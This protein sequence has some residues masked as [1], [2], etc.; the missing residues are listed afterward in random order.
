LLLGLASKVGVRNILFLLVIGNTFP[1]LS[2]LTNIDAEAARIEVDEQSNEC[3]GQASCSNDIQILVNSE[4]DGEQGP[5]GP[6]GPEGP[7]GENGDTG[8]QGPQGEQGPAGPEGAKGD[9]GEP[10]PQGLQG[11]QGIQGETGPQGLQGDQGPP[12]PGVEFGTLIVIKKVI[13]LNLGNAEASDFIMHVEG[14]HQSPDTFPGSETGTEVT[15]GFGSYRVTE[16][17]PNTVIQQHTFTQFSQDCSGVI[18][19]DETKTCTV[20]NIFNPLS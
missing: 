7:Q 13:N 4:I 14:N 15:L 8:E 12:G 3:H 19:P 6:P 10:G 18:H 16:R 2:S 5:P 11:D 9:T 17:I 1:I 20:T